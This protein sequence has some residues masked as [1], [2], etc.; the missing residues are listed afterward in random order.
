MSSKLA[1]ISHDFSVEIGDLGYGSLRG[2]GEVDSGS[3][4]SALVHAGIKGIRNEVSLLVCLV[5]RGVKCD[6]MEDAVVRSYRA[7]QSA[8]N[9]QGA[10][11]LGWTLGP[12][13]N[14]TIA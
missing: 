12:I 2:T 14:G 9:L 5:I 6:R 8:C 4:Q 11:H 1:T 3:G 7:P 10:P 13:S